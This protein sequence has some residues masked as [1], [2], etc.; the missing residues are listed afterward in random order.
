MNPREVVL[1][2]TATVLG[3]LASAL[4]LRFFSSF[5]PKLS[6][7]HSSSNGEA[8]E[9]CISRGTIISWQSPFCLLS[10]PKIQTGIGYNGFPRG[11]SD[12]KLPWAKKSKNGDPLETK[13]PYVCHAEVNAIL[14]TNHAS[15]AGQRL[16]VTMYPCNECAKIIIQSGVTE[17]IYF[18]EKNMSSSDVAY[19]ASRKLLSLAGVKVR[20]HQPQMDRIFIKFQEDS[21]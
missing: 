19:V 17:V 1:V 20:K 4:A 2:S 15:A 11:C 8:A 9:K 21:R 13:Y 10:A 16:Y 18:V 7:S 3:A 14:N 5:K 6:A 12:D